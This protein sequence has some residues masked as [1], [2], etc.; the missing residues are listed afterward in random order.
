MELEQRDGLTVA[1]LIDLLSNIPVTRL[2][3]SRSLPPSVMATTTS[4]STATTSTAS[5]RGVT[6]M[7][8]T[9]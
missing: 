8:K 1:E 3:N 4:R 7:T 5:C 6:P 9:K 2:S